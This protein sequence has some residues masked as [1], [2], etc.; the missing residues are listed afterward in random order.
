MF[1]ACIVLCASGA[2]KLRRPEAAR[3][4]LRAAGLPAGAWTVR[5][6]GAVEIAAGATALLSGR[7]PVVLAVAVLYAG[8]AAFLASALLRH[9]DASCGCFAERDLPPSWLHV[10]LDGIAALAA[11]GFASLRPAPPGLAAFVSR[12]PGLGA[13]LVAG[14]ALIAWLAA[15]IV[16]LVPAAIV[17]YRGKIGTA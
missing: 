10:A 13:A 9:V 15:Q 4:A 6:L 16:L 2:S 14:S 1:A 5:G 3:R 12:S 8:F 17:S 7:T 11:L